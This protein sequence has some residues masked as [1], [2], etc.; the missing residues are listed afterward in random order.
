[1]TKRIITRALSARINDLVDKYMDILDVSDPPTVGIIKDK[2]VDPNELG[3]M[4]WRPDNPRITTI[5]IPKRV[6]KD[7]RLL[8][9]VIAHEMI[10]HRDYMRLSDDEMAR[11]ELRRASGALRRASGGGAEPEEDEDPIA[12]GPAFREGAE[13]INAIMGSGFVVERGGGPASQQ[14][15]HPASGVGLVTKAVLA[16]AGGL[17]IGKLWRTATHRSPSHAEPT[18]SNERGRYGKK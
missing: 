11:L 9:R 18:R 2:D 8:E 14:Q 5:G 17:I 13:R 12:H 6:L 16:V 4:S 10:H 7:D 3:S 1:M 15:S